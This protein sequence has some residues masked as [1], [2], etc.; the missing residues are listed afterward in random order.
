MK[1]KFVYRTNSFC[2]IHKVFHWLNNISWLNLINNWYLLEV[3]KIFDWINKIFFLRIATKYYRCTNK[4]LWI[5]PNPFL[6]KPKKICVIQKNRNQ[7]NYP[8]R[9]N[10]T[11]F[12]FAFNNMYIFYFYS[13]I[14]QNFGPK[15]SWYFNCLNQ[16]F[17]EQKLILKNYIYLLH[18]ENSFVKSTKIFC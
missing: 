18:W 12:N 8:L 17:G 4:K 13:N 10:G 2:W 14:T 6:S 7:T 16:V 3:T 9:L 11:N 15:Y 1:K 5:Q